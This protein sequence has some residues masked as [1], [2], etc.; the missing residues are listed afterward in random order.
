MVDAFYFLNVFLS[1]ALAVFQLAVWNERQVRHTVVHAI[2]D[3]RGV[4]NRRP[5]LLALLLEEL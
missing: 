4:N 3:V 1:A 2:K 5:S